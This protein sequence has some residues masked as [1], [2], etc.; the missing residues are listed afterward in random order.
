MAPQLL[1]KHCCSG[2]D[3]LRILLQVKSWE[4]DM[5]IALYPDCNWTESMDSYDFHPVHSQCSYLGLSINKS[6]KEDDGMMM[7]FRS[8]GNE[9]SLAQEVMYIM[10]A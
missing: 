5:Q 9:L 6:A 3:H 8:K 1:T 2:F 7:V 10:T 4:Y